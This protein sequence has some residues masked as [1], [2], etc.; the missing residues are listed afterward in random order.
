MKV[1]EGHQKPF[2]VKKI[3]SYGP[4]DMVHNIDSISYD[5]YISMFQ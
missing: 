4:Y 2:K 5:S 1:D 3:I